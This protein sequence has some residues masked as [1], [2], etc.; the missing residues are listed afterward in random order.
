MLRDKAL[1]G[2]WN[3]NSALNDAQIAFSSTHNVKHNILFD[4]NFLYVSHSEI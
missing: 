3:G 4:N 2:H 1:K